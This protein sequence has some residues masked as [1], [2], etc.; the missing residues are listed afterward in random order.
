[1][2]THDP[3]DNTTTDSHTSPPEHQSN[4]QHSVTDHVVTRPSRLVP[5]VDLLHPALDVPSN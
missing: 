3:E 1:M 5:N 2:V 4:K